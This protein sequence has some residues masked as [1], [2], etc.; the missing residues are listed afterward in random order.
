MMSLPTELVICCRWG[1]YK[2]SRRWRWKEVGRVSPLRAGGSAS[3][4]GAHGVQR[5]TGPGLPEIRLGTARNACSSEYLH[6]R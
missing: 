3:Q 4:D 2:M 5:P 1:F 6:E